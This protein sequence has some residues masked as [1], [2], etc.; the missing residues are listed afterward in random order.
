[1]RF[2]LKSWSKAEGE[3]H[4]KCLWGLRPYSG[5]SW[6]K[7][8]QRFPCDERDYPALES[9]QIIVVH[10]VEHVFILTEMLVS[11]VQ[12]GVRRD[13]SDVVLS[14]KPFADTLRIGDR[15]GKLGLVDRQEHAYRL[16][17]SADRFASQLNLE[18]LFPV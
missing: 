16:H 6:L 1:M 14:K 18:T 4:L 15:N 13:D 5:V 7:D 9:A 2:C 12:R 17:H 10:D 8:G 11:P 3:P